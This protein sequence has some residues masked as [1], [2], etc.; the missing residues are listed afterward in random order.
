MFREI[1]DHVLRSYSTKLLEEFNPSKAKN[2]HESHPK[3]NIHSIKNALEEVHEEI[4]LGKKTHQAKT[5]EEMRGNYQKRVERKLKHL[6]KKINEVEAY[7]RSEA[8]L[9]YWRQQF[10]SA[11]PELVQSVLNTAAD[12]IHTGTNI[13]YNPGITGRAGIEKRLADALHDLHRDRYDV[14]LDENTPLEVEDNAVLL[15]TILRELSRKLAFLATLGIFL[16]CNSC[17]FIVNAQAP[18]QHQENLRIPWILAD[19]ILLLSLY[20]IA[21][22]VKRSLRE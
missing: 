8:G 9:T 5:Y 2:W 3:L 21:N 18:S 13:L 19:V 16:S 17:A 14:K 22:R 20:V 15:S 12:E 10:I 11:P 1:S 6:E 7:L 4:R